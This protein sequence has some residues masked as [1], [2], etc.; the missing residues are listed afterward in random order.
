MIYVLRHGQT[1]LNKERRMQGR[2][3][4]PLNEFGRQ[5]AERLRDKLKTIKFD[6]VFTSPQVRAIQTAEIVTGMKAIVDP[7]LD[8]FDIGEADGLK[9]SEVKMNGVLPDTC[10][11]KGVEDARFFLERVFHFM[12]ELDAIKREK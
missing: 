1:D 10:V 9:I 2:H 11:Y 4:L 3:G 12:S 6:L 5:Q 7:R 8:V